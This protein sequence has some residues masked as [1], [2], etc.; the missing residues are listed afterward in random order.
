MSPFNRCDF[1]DLDEMF[2]VFDDIKD[3]ERPADMEAV[4]CRRMWVLVFFL[5]SSWKWIPLQVKDFLY[6]D[7]PGFLGQFL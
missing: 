3:S 2:I 4:H 1:L 7:T 6:D 5:V